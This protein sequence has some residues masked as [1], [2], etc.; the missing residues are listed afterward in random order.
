MT[1][2]RRV[3]WPD[4]EAPQWADPLQVPAGDRRLA[5]AVLLGLGE[6]PAAS[7]ARSPGTWSPCSSASTRRASRCRSTS[8]CSPT[9]TRCSCSGWTTWSPSR[10]PRRR[11]S[12]PFAQFLEREGTCLVIGPH[13]DVGRSADLKERD[14]EYRHHGDALVPR[15]QRFGGYTRS[16]MKG[17]GIPVEN[18][19]GPAA[20]ARRVDRDTGPGRP[21]IAPLT[22]RAGPGY[23]RLARGGHATSTS[24]CTCRTTR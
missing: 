4:Y 14:M 8:A 7:S 15:Q 23:A 21:S 2:V 19:C 6:V 24:T 3:F 16:L 20:R 12:R 22:H 11:R 10:R 9:R 18:R 13:H 5:G 1:E 17:L